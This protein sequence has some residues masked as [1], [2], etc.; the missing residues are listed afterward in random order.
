[1]ANIFQ[2]AGKYWEKD[3]TEFEQTNPNTL[4]RIYRSLTPGVGFG[5]ALGSMQSASSRGDIPGMALATVDAI[6]LL[7]ALKNMKVAGHG[8]V[9]SGIVKSL[10]WDNFLKVLGANTGTGLTN[11]GYDNINKPEIK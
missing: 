9:K 4:Q 6:P 10:D 7:A 3:N 11:D 2:D 5:S 1:M 8:A